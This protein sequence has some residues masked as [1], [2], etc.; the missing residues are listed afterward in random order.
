MDEPVA[1]DETTGAA[2]VRAGTE[3]ISGADDDGTA[4]DDDGTDDD[5]NDDAVSGT[6][7]PQPETAVTAIVQAS[8]AVRLTLIKFDIL[9]PFIN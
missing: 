4:S 2:L 6:F 8:S 3:D 9:S 7:F 1:L 5:D